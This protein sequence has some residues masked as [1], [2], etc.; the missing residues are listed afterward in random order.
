[1]AVTGAPPAKV[2]DSP[3]SFFDMPAAYPVRTENKTATAK[4]TA[5]NTAQSG[6]VRF[7]FHYPFVS[8]DAPARRN[9]GNLFIGFFLFANDCRGSEESTRRKYGGTRHRAAAAFRSAAFRLFGAA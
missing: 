4:A 8:A 9:R 6:R 5:D 3:L 1:M 7:S 2:T